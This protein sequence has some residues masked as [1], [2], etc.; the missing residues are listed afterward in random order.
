[1]PLA[2]YLLWCWTGLLRG[3]PLDTFLF[4][5]SR[6]YLY[7]LAG[8]LIFQF[9]DDSTINWFE[10]VLMALGSI[11]AALIIQTRISGG[12]PWLGGY[13]G[14]SLHSG[15]LLPCAFVIAFTRIRLNDPQRLRS[16]SLLA[17]ILA[18]A[19]AMFF[20]HSRTGLILMAVLLVFLYPRKMM[21]IVAAAAVF[22]IA[23]TILRKG[24]ILLDLRI[25][26]LGLKGTAARL[27]IWATDVDAIMARP[28]T[29]WG[30]GNF[31]MAYL[32]FQHPGGYGLRYGQSTMFAH[33]GLLQTAAETGLP[34]AILLLWGF[35]TLLKNVIPLVRKERSLF[36]IVIVFLMTS[37]VNYSLFL[38]FNGLIFTTAVA[39]LAAKSTAVHRPHS[40]IDLSKFRLVPT[41]MIGLLSAF[42]MSYGFSEALQKNGKLSVAAKVCPIRS[43]AWYALAL[44]NMSN[45]KAA[46]PFLERALI[47]NNQNSFYWQRTALVLIHIQPTEESK[48]NLCF[49]QAQSLAPFHAPFYVQEGFY[50]LGTLQLEM[51]KKLFKKAVSLEPA[52]TLPHYGLALVYQRAGQQHAARVELDLVRS[53]ESKKQEL[54]R[55]P[56]HG[57]SYQELFNSS[58]ARFLFG[59]DERQS[60][61][62]TN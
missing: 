49:K 41:F 4:F 24:G 25:D 2:L 37:M 30:L 53:L 11:E 6:V 56:V 46:I 9:G 51:A 5:Y 10:V 50:R 1:M 45:L 52:T 26:S 17:A 54:E 22:A 14:N 23:W 43:E 55:D 42:L 31:E 62:K 21:W 19:L 28:I 18:T 32:Q 20:L 44:Q 13:L 60:Q 57:S 58:Y 16:I 61:G 48:I 12:A 7:N 34:G 47:T 59:V 38:P 40:T 36:S 8:I 27:G 33:N 39:L 15:I 29:G 3:A 35:A